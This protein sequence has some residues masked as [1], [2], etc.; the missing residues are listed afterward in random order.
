MDCSLPGSSLHGIFQAIVLEWIAISF[1]RGSSQPRDQTRVS[2]IVDRCFTVWA[3]REQCMATNENWWAF[4]PLFQN[5]LSKGLRGCTLLLCRFKRFVCPWHSQ[6]VIL[7]VMGLAAGVS[8]RCRQESLW[9]TISS[10]K[11]WN[12]YS[13][14]HG[15]HSWRLAQMTVKTFKGYKRSYVGT[16][17]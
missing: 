3:T 11:T 16:V 15:K 12:D 2:C 14:T 13:W 8:G 10:G 5:H 4:S 17:G 9:T 7:I 1:S 6:G